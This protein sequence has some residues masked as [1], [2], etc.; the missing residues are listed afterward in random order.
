MLF[1]TF[2]SLIHGSIEIAYFQILAKTSLKEKEYFERYNSYRVSTLW[3]SVY[4]ST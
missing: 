1:M 3:L 2:L 4:V